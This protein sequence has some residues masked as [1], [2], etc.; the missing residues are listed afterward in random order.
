[1]GQTMGPGGQENGDHLEKNGR[2]HSLEVY[3]LRS[4]RS[5]ITLWRYRWKSTH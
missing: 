3:L 1:M 5:V 4:V 2:N